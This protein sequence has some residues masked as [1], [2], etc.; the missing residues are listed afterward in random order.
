MNCQSWL[1]VVYFVDGWKCNL[2]LLTLEQVVN[3]G[4][5]NNLTKVIVDNVLQY[6]CHDFNFGFVTKS[7]TWKGA[8]E[9]A[10][11]ESH[12]HSWECERVEGN[13]PTHSQVDSHFGSFSFYKVFNFKK[14]ISGG[15][16]H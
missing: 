7:K 16:I 8:A 6:E 12:S 5:T 1:G 14:V 2:V 11:Q 15:Q 4:T 10:T 9:S 13:E 3:G